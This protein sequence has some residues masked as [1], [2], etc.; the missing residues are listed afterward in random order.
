MV[1]TC[2][3]EVQGLL[4]KA[5]GYFITSLGSV[6][7]CEGKVA[8]VK[9]HFKRAVVLHERSAQDIIGQANDFYQ[10]GYVLYKKLGRLEELCEH[11]ERSLTFHE[12][13]HNRQS[14]ANILNDLGHVYHMFDNIKHA[15][16]PFRKPW[17]FT[18]LSMILLARQTTSLASRTFISGCTSLLGPKQHTRK[19]MDLRDRDKCLRPHATRPTSPGATY[20]ESAFGHELILCS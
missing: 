3:P 16:D 9:E 13:H 20:P 1:V 18:K 5:L 2:A 17:S 4:D 15:K 7:F 12:E 8:V 6:S 10:L 11:Y 19:S 14:L